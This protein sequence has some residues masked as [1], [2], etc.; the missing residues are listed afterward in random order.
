LKN[1]KH[2][3]K[4]KKQNKKNK[5]NIIKSLF[6]PENQKK[7]QKH[8]GFDLSFARLDLLA[9]FDSLLIFQFESVLDLFF[10]I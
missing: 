4:G 3:Q 1:K 8:P 10:L 2:I 9:F 5:Q 6:F 7:H